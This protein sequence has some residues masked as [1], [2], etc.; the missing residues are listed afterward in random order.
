MN[1]KT[2]Q[3]WMVF[4]YLNCTQLARKIICHF[5]VSSPYLCLYIHVA[6]FIIYSMEFTKTWSD[7][8]CKVW[9]ENL[10]VTTI[11]ISGVRSSQ[12]IYIPIPYVRKFRCIDIISLKLSSNKLNSCAKHLAMILLISSLYSYGG[13]TLRLAA[14]F[15][16]LIWQRWSAQTV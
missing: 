15:Q 6:D 3:V 8:R 12:S 11:D 1:S 7:V 4:C 14:L 13:I 2:Q 5:T 10:S 9:S 16:Q